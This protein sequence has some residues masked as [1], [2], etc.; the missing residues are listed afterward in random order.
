MM[1]DGSSRGFSGFA[2][3]AIYQPV[4]RAVAI[5]PNRHSSSI[6]QAMVKPSHGPPV[7][8]PY[9]RGPSAWGIATDSSASVSTQPR[10][11]RQIIMDAMSM[12]TGPLPSS[13]RFHP[14][15][16]PETTM[17]TPSAQMSI[18]R[19]FFWSG[20]CFFSTW[21]ADMEKS[22]TKNTS[23]SNGVDVPYFDGAVVAGGGKA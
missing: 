5:I 8:S 10:K 21:I 4:A 22:P 3:R 19:S 23:R 1:S 16:W 13:P 9:A 14:K 2:R 20:L 17:P 11:R 6:D 18:T 15:Y 7:R 12:A